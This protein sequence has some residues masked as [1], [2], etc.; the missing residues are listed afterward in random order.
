MIEEWCISVLQLSK[1]SSGFEF[2]VFPSSKPVALWRL[3]IPAFPTYLPKAEIGRERFIPF[4]RS[5]VQRENVNSLVQD[6]NSACW[7]HFL[8]LITVTPYMLS[9]ILSINTLICIYGKT[10]KDIE[11]SGLK[12]LVDIS[13]KLKQSGRDRSKYLWKNW[14]KSAKWNGICIEK[15]Q[16]KANSNTNLEEN[17]MIEQQRNNP[18]VS[19]IEWKWYWM[20]SHEYAFNLDNNFGTVIWC[21]TS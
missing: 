6:L 11:A 8:M 18:R 16:M 7:V 9:W 15:S 2:R 10:S 20:L 3:K 19:V 21:N 4:L 12:I 13:W 14:K 17:K 1:H 5:L